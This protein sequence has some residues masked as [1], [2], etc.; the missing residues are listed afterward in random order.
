MKRECQCIYCGSTATTRD[1]VPPKIFLDL[2]LDDC[3]TVPSCLEC[4]QR[5][6][7][8]DEFLAYFIEF[9]RCIEIDDKSERDKIK[10]IYNHSS[11]I[12]DRIF[13]SLL[14]E[15]SIDDI[16]LVY[17]EIENSRIDSFL[18]RLAIAHIFLDGESIFSSETK[19]RVAYFFAKPLSDKKYEILGFEPG[20]EK[21]FCDDITW[22]TAQNHNDN[23][24][25]FVDISS[26]KV[27]IKI[28]DC[29]FARI[30]WS[31]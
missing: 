24:C 20:K 4:N 26:Q 17:L 27:L 16:K 23:Y 8:D 15:T 18:R 28:R 1:H 11:S 7:K 3:K 13:N 10:K 22:N 9:M 6:G 30:D 14:T 19:W 31:F 2:P 29:F 12:E 21:V 25:Y 5:Y